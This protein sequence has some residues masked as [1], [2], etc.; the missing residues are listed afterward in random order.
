MSH[1]NYFPPFLTSEIS[2]DINVNVLFSL[3]MSKLY[4]VGHLIEYLSRILSPLI[5]RYVKPMST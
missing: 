2:K 3:R 5:D 4:D 1:N